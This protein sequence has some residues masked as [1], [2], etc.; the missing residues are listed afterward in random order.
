MDSVIQMITIEEI[1]DVYTT[2]WCEKL[3][4]YIERRKTPL[5]QVSNSM[6][7]KKMTKF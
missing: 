3:F 7:N 6:I 2:Q 5:T 1:L 4:G